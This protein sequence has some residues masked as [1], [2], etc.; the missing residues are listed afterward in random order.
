MSMDTFKTYAGESFKVDSLV[1]AKLL[2]SYGIR[3][4]EL[5]V[6]LR[7]EE[8]MPPHIDKYLLTREIGAKFSS[9][10]KV[11]PE[12]PNID[13]LWEALTLAVKNSTKGAGRDAGDLFLQSGVGPEEFVSWLA[14]A[15][16][17]MA[18][19]FEY[20]LDPKASGLLDMFYLALRTGIYVKSTPYEDW[21][22]P[23]RKNTLREIYADYWHGEVS[24][25][26]AGLRRNPRE[27]ARLLALS[28]A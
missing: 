13:K 14:S 23:K 4:P 27:M 26:W 1:L 25:A 11:I 15:A 18:Q 22:L 16:G 28:V 19:S 17:D 5:G 10:R 20:A 21:S 24:K 9:P 2:H 3:A 12:G 7:G 6:L 8:P